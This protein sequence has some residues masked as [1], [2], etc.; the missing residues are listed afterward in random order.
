MCSNSKCIDPCVETCGANA[1]CEAR[2][3][4]PVCSCPAGHTGD[5]FVSCRRFDPGKVLYLFIGMII[6]LFNVLPQHSN[7]SC[8]HTITKLLFSFFLKKS[9]WSN[10]AYLKVSYNFG[11]VF[12]KNYLTNSEARRGA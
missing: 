12:T 6:S 2:N 3:H 4:L 1:N 7:T 5:P 11:V 8:F 9:M 10:L